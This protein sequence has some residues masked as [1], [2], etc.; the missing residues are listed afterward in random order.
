[1]AKIYAHR[2]DSAYAPENTL[3]AFLLA[4]TMGAQ[5]IELDVQLTRDGQVAVMHDE[6]LKRTTREK[7]LLRD[8]TLEQLKRMDAGSHFSLNFQGEK[9]PTLVEVIY[10]LKPTVLELNIE[11]KS[12]F[13]TYQAGL[14]EKVNRKIVESGMG[15]RII[16]S[17]FDHKCLLEL[18][19]LNPKIAIGLLYETRM[20]HPG[21]YARAL[22]ADAVHPYHGNLD[23][24]DAAECRRLG[25]RINPWTVDRPED[26]K[27][28]L[29]LGVDAI[30]T[31]KPDIEL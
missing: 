5:G 14:V 12:S 24:E 4:N 6:V 1:M 11:I 30:I 17:S 8:Y 28:M 25:I 16:V 7:G 9:I 2:G 19:A 23:E 18:R 29:A 20:V 22:G 27:R 26:V 13:L 15:E 31:N 3:S 21:E 10:F